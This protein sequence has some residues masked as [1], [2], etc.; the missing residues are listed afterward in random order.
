[1]KFFKGLVKAELSKNKIVFGVNVYE[2]KMNHEAEKEESSD[3]YED[4]EVPLKKTKTNQ[5]AD[6]ACCSKTLVKSDLKVE[7]VPVFV[8]VLIN[9]TFL[10]FLNIFF[11]ILAY[12]K[13]FHAHL[14]L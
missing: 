12:S 10:L 8:E 14:L 7:N 2:R 11:L 4:N 13:S 9:L 6:N 1:M 5:V 3:G